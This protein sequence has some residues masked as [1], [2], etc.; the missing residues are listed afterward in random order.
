MKSFVLLLQS[1]HT[2]IEQV[3]VIFHTPNL[4]AELLLLKTPVVFVS[5]VVEPVVSCKHFVLVRY[6]R[7]H[8]INSP[9]DLLTVPN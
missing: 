8:V 6:P 3:V 7:G 2:L 4:F 1:E 5:R 9:N